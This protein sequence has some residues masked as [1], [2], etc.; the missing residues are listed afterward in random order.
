MKLS[1]FKGIL[2]IS[3]NLKAN[4]LCTQ[5][6]IDDNRTS[7]LIKYITALEIHNHLLSLLFSFANSP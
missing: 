1:A 5:L 7:E 3:E 6:K 2:S 4:I